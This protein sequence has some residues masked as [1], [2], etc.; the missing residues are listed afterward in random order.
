MAQKKPKLELDVDKR[1]CRMAKCLTYFHEL[2]QNPASFDD[3]WERSE[4]ACLGP[5]D[6][7][8]P[9]VAHD[10]IRTYINQS[11]LDAILADWK[12]KV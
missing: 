10:K 5:G 8:S 2:A 7:D 9:Q 1:L 3:A 11:T 12:S 4:T 6:R